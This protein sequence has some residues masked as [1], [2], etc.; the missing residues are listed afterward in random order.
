MNPI[1]C[2]FIDDE[3]AAHEIMKD[4]I[5][6]TEYLQLQES[7]FSPSEAIRYLTD[8]PVELLF[9]DVKMP[10]MTG[11]NLLKSLNR[12]PLT[13]L[14]TAYPEYALEGYELEVVDYLVKPFSFDRFMQSVQKIRKRLHLLQDKPSASDFLMIKVDRKLVKV[15]LSE[16]VYIKSIGDYLKVFVN[17]TCYITKNTLHSMATL[18]RGLFI[19]I[20]KSYLVNIKHIRFMEGNQVMTSRG[21]LPV[22]Q[23][24]RTELIRS[25]GFRDIQNPA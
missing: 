11:I 8:N 16:L 18:T 19:Q 4:F 10:E 9:L 2:V 21:L 25:L 13:I 5:G 3:P 7:F 1:K 15:E 20:H 24:Y 12:P 22:G 14:C 17:D 23:K 6:K